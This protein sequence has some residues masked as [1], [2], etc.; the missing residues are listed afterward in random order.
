MSYQRVSN[1]R[2][3]E[4]VVK[5]LKE[6]IFEGRYRP[7]QRIP[8]EHELV[9]IFGVSRVIVREAVRDLERSGLI[10]VKRGPKGGAIVQPMKHDAVTMVMRDVLHLGRAR[11]ADI[12]E[13]RLQV[14][15]I[16]AGLAAQ[17]ATDLDLKGLRSNLQSRP[18]SP[19]DEFVSWNVNFHRLVARASQ[20]PMYDIL[21]NILMD[22]T[23]DLILSLQPP[24]RVSH[25]PHW[26]PAI[27]QKIAQRDAQG[28]ERLFR[29]HLQDIVPALQ[30]LEAR[31]PDNKLH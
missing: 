5:Q 10:R 9:D 2:L 12:M 19:G 24:D 15:P 29:E 7:G 18:D 20:N 17:R 28:A 4:R 25:A 30:D 6:S 16:V 8:S 22:F 27:Y 23:E 14:E 13:V 1:P 31:F 26:H 11:V 3:A 21:V